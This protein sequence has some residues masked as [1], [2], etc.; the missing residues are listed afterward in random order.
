MKLQVLDFSDCKGAHSNF[1]KKLGDKLSFSERSFHN[2]SK[3]VLSGCDL[4]SSDAQGI[5]DFAK[6]ITTKCE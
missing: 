4:S 3:V 1:F 5:I 6:S 2:L